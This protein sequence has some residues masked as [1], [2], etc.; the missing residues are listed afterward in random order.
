MFVIHVA[1][2]VRT[3]SLMMK[4]VIPDAAPTVRGGGGQG[5]GGEEALGRGLDGRGADDEGRVSKGVLAVAA[6]FAGWIWGVDDP[7]G[8]LIYH[9]NR[10]IYIHTHTHIYICVCI[11]IYI[12]IIVYYSTGGRRPAA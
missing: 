7:K 10:Y 11:Y 12:Y 3:Y 9:L 4:Q 6:E 5:G 2:F 8:Y 1:M